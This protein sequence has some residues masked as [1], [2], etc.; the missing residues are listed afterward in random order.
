MILSKAQ[1]GALWIAEGGP[2][3]EAGRAAEVS[4]RE[5]G[6]NTRVVNK[7]GAVGLMQIY[8]GH[9]P[10]PARIRELQDPRQNMREA[11]GKF[12]AAGGWSPWVVCGSQNSCPTIPKT[13][14]AGLHFPNLH[15]PFTPNLPD[16]TPSIPNPLAQ[17]EALGNVAEVLKGFLATW[18]ELLKK[19]M[20]PNTWKDIGKIWL[21]IILLT[22]GLRRIF[23][24]VT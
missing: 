16:I 9:Y 8:D 10:S 21:G 12:K 22:I 19:I 2:S 3:D 6:R 18:L 11:V 4:T 13:V 14:N 15:L 24:V 7:I 5:S 17:A 20:D 23:T 1:V